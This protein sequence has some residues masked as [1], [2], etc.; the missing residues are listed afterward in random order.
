VLF[1]FALALAWLTSFLI[2][3]TLGMLVFWTHSITALRATLTTATVLFAGR[4]A[5]LDVLPPLFQTIA[6]LL[7]F[8][9]ILAF[10]TELAIGRLTFHE[11]LNGFVMQIVWIIAGFVG[12]HY[13][14]NAG[15][16]RYSAVGG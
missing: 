9:W 3:Y 2:D 10:P 1:P 13:L 16:H 11:T 8:R 6:N 12:L 4:L 7:P 15:I 5:P 14:W